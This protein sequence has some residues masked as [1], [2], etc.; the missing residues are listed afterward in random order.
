MS[1]GYFDHQEWKLQDIALE[2][3]EAIEESPYTEETLKRIRL[4]IKMLRDVHRRV[5][6]IDYLLSGD[7]GEQSFN[8]RWEKDIIAV[9]KGEDEP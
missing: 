1:G 8:E 4:T 5:H 2:M 9:L 3:E 6:R 7:D